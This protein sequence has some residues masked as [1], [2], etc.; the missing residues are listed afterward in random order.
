MRRRRCATAS[1]S[2][3]RSR[4]RPTSSTGSISATRFPTSRAGR[5]KRRTSGRRIVVHDGE[6]YL[7]YYSATHDACHDPERGHCLA[8]A[9]RDVARRAV[10]RHGHAAAARRRLRIY[11]PDGVRRPRDAASACFIG[12]RASSRSRCRSWPRTGCHSLRA[13]RRS[14]SS[15]PI[16]SKAPSRG[17]SKP[18]G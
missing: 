9:T 3:S 13:A 8:V 4:A 16:R 12:A 1:G 2:T 18:P 10:R 6:R 14:T 17:W 5:G 11:R 15:G 7:M